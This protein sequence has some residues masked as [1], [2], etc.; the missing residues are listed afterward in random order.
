MTLWFVRPWPT[1]GS[2]THTSPYLG[3]MAATVENAVLRRF[4]CRLRNERPLLGLIGLESTQGYSQQPPGLMT[5]MEMRSDMHNIRAVVGNDRTLT[6]PGLISSVLQRLTQTYIRVRDGTNFP[7]S[8]TLSSG[9]ELHAQA[10]TRFEGSAYTYAR[11][12]LEGVAHPG[13]KR[14]KDPRPQQSWVLQLVR[15][16]CFG[17]IGVE[18]LPKRQRTGICTALEVLARRGTLGS[19]RSPPVLGKEEMICGLACGHRERIHR[20]LGS[21]SLETRRRRKMLQGW[22]ACLIPGRASA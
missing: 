14:T 18:S 6:W 8:L 15:T 5:K 20:S 16:P 3:H 17:M 7:K 22:I 11:A 4:E 2:S 9:H 21:L 1:V 10:T 12:S 13:A 19:E